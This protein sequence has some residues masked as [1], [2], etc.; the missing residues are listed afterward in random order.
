M[1]EER[2]VVAERARDVPAH[3]AAREP[4][5]VVPCWLGRRRAQQLD[6]AKPEGAHAVVLD[7]R[8]LAV[9]VELNTRPGRWAVSGRL[10][11]RTLDL[12]PGVEGD[13]AEER[14]TAGHA[15]DWRLAREGG[16]GVAAATGIAARER[17]A[18]ADGVGVVGERDHARV[19]GLRRWVPQIVH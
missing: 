2:L 3:G 7:A 6:A 17:R 15:A 11:A 5:L 1:E 8:D 18:R 12:A 4:T 10:V 16:R 19:V 9:K 13:V 14:H